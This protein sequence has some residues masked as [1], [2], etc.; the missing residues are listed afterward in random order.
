MGSHQLKPSSEADPDK[1]DLS[2][3]DGSDKYEYQGIRSSGDG[4]YVLV[5][6]AVKKH[7]VLH[8]VDS[9]FDMNLTSTPWD[10]DPASLR[11][12]YEQLQSSPKIRRKSATQ[13]KSKT[14]Q[15][16][17]TSTDTK[18]RKAEKPKKAKTPPREPTPDAE[19]E[20]S[21]DGL[22]VEYPGG[23]PPPRFPRSIPQQHKKE[24]LSEESDAD[25]EYEEDDDNE[26][27]RDVEMLELPPAVNAVN[28]EEEDDVDLEADL[29]AELEQ[30]LEKE[31]G[32]RVDESSESEEE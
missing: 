10:Q 16:K 14:A 20:D 1:Y 21:D 27:N 3:T 2:F 17:A 6:D 8:Q 5:F 25:A 18:R 28:A 32:A 23:A 4:K 31:T 13:P 29:A 30:A 24:E 22:T 12:S 19:D 7:F 26:H 9:S 15:P 11:E